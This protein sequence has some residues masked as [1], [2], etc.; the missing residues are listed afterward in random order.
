MSTSDISILYIEH[1]RAKTILI[2]Y[3]NLLDFIWKQYS[4]VWEKFAPARV[5]EL[6]EQVTKMANNSTRLQY[7]YKYIFSE[8]CL[9]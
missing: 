9:F 8:Q 3:W 5:T 6:E 1:F 7:L 4:F 2:L